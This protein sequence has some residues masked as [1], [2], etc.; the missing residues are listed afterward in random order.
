MKNTA[1]IVVILGV[2]ALN[3]FITVKMALALMDVEKK[4]RQSPVGRFL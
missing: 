1:L 2:T 3:L 4:I